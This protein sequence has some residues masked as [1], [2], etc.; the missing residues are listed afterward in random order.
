MIVLLGACSTSLFDNA[1]PSGHHDPDAPDGPAPSYCDTASCFTSAGP[2]LDGTPRGS[3]G[4]WRYLEDHRDRTWVAMTGDASG[5]HGAVPDI[6][7]R[8]CREHAQEI[9]ECHELA[10]GVLLSTSTGAADPALELTLPSSQQFTLSVASF[11]TDGHSAQQLRIYRNSREDA[12]ATLTVQPGAAAH[13][14]EFVVDALAGDRFLVAAAPADGASPG[15]IALQIYA[16]PTTKTMFPSTCQLAWTFD[17]AAGNTV[18][19][20]CG[21]VMTHAIFDGADT[22][23]ALAAGPYPELGKAIDLN[24]TE[25]GYSTG[26]ID[27]SHDTTLQ[28]WM[29]FRGILEPYDAWPFSDLDLNQ[30]GGLGVALTETTPLRFDVQTTTA[31]NGSN[32]ETADGIG[33]YPTDGAWHFLRVVHAG[34]NVAVCVDGHRQAQFALAECHLQ[35]TFSPWIGANQRWSPQGG[36]FNGLLDDVRI[37]SLALPCDP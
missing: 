18:A 13:T 29:K 22:P 12:L 8:P 31:F 9:E 26:V 23:P 28:F 27:R 5:L 33:A 32:I 14:D 1:S 25:Y 34:G 36:H 15:A 2:E 20:A 37:Y 6:Q 11:V 21:P 30:P 24:D 4:R 16:N 10:T 17:A 7:I 3:S 19:N 35:S